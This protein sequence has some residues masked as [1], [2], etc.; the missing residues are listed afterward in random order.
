MSFRCRSL[1]VATACLATHI[2]FASLVQAQDAGSVLQAF[3]DAATK[4]IEQSESA[5]VAVSRL[6]QKSTS[7]S[8]PARKNVFNLP[9]EPEPAVQS[10]DPFLG[11]YLPTDFG[12][13]VLVAPPNKPNERL[14]LT[15]YHLVR[16]G[17]TVRDPEAK[18]DSQIFIQLPK[19]QS[20]EAFIY[21]AD[22]RS[23]LAV[24]KL[25]LR[26][27]GAMQ[28]ENLP[29]IPLFDG[30]QLRKGQLVFVIGNP[31]A[32][33]RDGAPT[34]SFGMVGNLARMPFV[35]TSIARTQQN[36]IHN[37]GTLIQVDTRLNIGTSGGALLNR[38]GQLVGVTTSL[39]A[40]QGYET[41]VGFAIPINR[42]TRRIVES[43]LNGMEAEYGLLGLVP[44]TQPL[45]N[46]HSYGVPSGQRS[47]VRIQSVKQN[48]PAAQAGLQPGQIVLAINNRPVATDEDLMREVGLAGPGAKI[49]L[50]LFGM[51]VVTATAGK[52]PAK[53]TD[54]II[55][56]IDR[57]PAWRG[58]KID[59]PT[60][61]EEHTDPNLDI[62][63]PSGVLVIATEAGSSAA[64]AQ[65]RSGQ[66]IAE[67]GGKP[68]R[69]PDQFQEAVKTLRGDALIKLTDGKVLTIR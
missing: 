45:D 29:A 31:Y 24:L 9:N 23:D 17:R 33:A 68:V 53:E 38:Q 14:V 36:S 34:I 44:K 4:L 21:A 51:R 50:Q 64:N 28:E 7:F 30:D 42:N 43:L 58:L 5:V 19:S 2:Q 61:R 41:S 49:V 3:E 32:L 47:V 18:S 39:A 54:A 62:P 60:A 25:D 10:H 1:I 67:I 57:Y 48:S 40:L 63:Y 22:P 13:G 69:N 46:G 26:R 12:T 15:N 20:F 37:F 52:W 66:I 65:L 27:N 55:T 56:A 11:N 35:D 6:P 59:W 16:G 8:R